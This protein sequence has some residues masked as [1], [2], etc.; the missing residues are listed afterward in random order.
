M[1]IETTP[2][3]DDVVQAEYIE[4]TRP[5]DV[6]VRGPV[7]TRELPAK[8]A[9]YKTDQAVGTSV[10]VKVLPLEPRRKSAI[11]IPVSQD[12]WISASQAGAQSGAAGAMRWPAAV[13]YV[14]DHMEEVWVCAVTGTTDV[15]SESRMWSE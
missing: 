8:G 13:P 1:N 14:V 5:V 2:E 4:A 10:A 9:G 12:V 15:G 6:V 7:Q 11:I 3:P